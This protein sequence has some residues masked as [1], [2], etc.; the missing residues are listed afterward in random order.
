MNDLKTVLCSRYK[1][2]PSAHHVEFVGRSSSNPYGS[3][4]TASLAL[5]KTDIHTAVIQSIEALKLM[6]ENAMNSKE[7]SDCV[8]FIFLVYDHSRY[9]KNQC[10]CYDCRHLVYYSKLYYL[11]TDGME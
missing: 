7:V 4:R 1:L 11:N 10:F 8:L 6:K 9:L 5:G 3:K 2:S